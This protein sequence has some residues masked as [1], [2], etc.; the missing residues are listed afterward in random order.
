MVEVEWALNQIKDNKALGAAGIQIELIKA[1]GDGMLT[2]ITTL[3]NN[4]WEME[5]ANRLGEVY[6]H[7]SS[8]YARTI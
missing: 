5:M 4:I 7:T 1:A 3:C 6:T 2:E 8:K